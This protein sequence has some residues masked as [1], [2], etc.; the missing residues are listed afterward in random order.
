MMPFGSNEH[1][2][3]S[4]ELLFTFSPLLLL[5]MDVQPAGLPFYLL[6]PQGS[7]DIL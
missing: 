3:Q 5:Q 1:Y 2:A 7:L 6:S 4:S